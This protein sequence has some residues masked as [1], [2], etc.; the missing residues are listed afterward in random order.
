[1][2]VIVIKSSPKRKEFSVTHTLTEQF[3]LGMR[4]ANAEVEEFHLN[5]MSIHDCMDCG[6]CATISQGKCVMQDDMTN[7]IYPKF[8][9]ADVMVLASPIY[10]GTVN[11]VMKR[12]IERLYPFLG[13]WQQVDGEGVYQAFRGPFP[14]VVA[15]SA[16]SWHY[17]HVF[18]Q[19][20]SYYHYLFEDRLVAE[21][22]RGSSESFQFGAV[23]YQKKIE[24]LEAMKQAGRELVEKGAPSKETIDFVC[25]DVGELEKTVTMHN[26]SI[27]LCQE[28]NV[29]ATQYAINRKEDHGAI[30]PRSID[31][32][33][34]VVRLFF[35]ETSENINVSV[36]FLVKGKQKEGCFFKIEE[37]KLSMGKEIL[38]HADITLKASLDTIAEI[39]GKK[40]SLMDMIMKGKVIVKG[41]IEELD[42]VSKFVFAQ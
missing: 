13:P 24:M 4:E 35:Q 9:E 11:A 3:V 23:F 5:Q 26:L 19:M 41:K 16:A 20:S 15:I 14:K 40:A 1:M 34:D 31:S 27:K 37:G 30:L 18:D 28:E 7:L 2:K 6:S 38:E 33:M 39:I 22:Y 12:F 36:Q 21:L 25:Q 8:L 29:N 42:K 10:F 17:S 32:F